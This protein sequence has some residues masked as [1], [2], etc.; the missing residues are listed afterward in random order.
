VKS[1]PATDFQKYRALYEFVENAKAQGLVS[2]LIGHITKKGQ[3]AGP[4]DLE[5]NV[6]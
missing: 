6:D 4:K 5:H 3:I 2:L 1:K